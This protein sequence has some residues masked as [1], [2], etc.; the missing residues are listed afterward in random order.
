MLRGNFL[1]KLVGPLSMADI[2]LCVSSL[3][4]EKVWIKMKFEDGRYA[5]KPI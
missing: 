2:T 3:R 4:M 5:T 1:V